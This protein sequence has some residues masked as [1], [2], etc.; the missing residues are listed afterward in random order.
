MAGPVR[1]HGVIHQTIEDILNAINGEAGA[2][3]AG[4]SLAGQDIVGNSLTIGPYTPDP[5]AVATNGAAFPAGAYVGIGGIALPIPTV[6]TA[7]WSASASAATYTV[8][9][10]VTR[11]G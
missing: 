4:K 5:T 10:R 8:G 6:T 2:G 9:N 7:A 3:I 11:R 1:D